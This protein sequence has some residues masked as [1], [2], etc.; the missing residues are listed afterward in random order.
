M[1]GG[2]IKGLFAEAGETREGGRRRGKMQVG[3]LFQTFKIPD[4]APPQPLQKLNSVSWELGILRD[5]LGLANDL[6]HD[7]EKSVTPCCVS[8]SH[9]EKKARKLVIN[10]IH[11]SRRASL[12]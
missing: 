10:S 6:W 8:P 5:R 4:R 11:H 12:R 7:L 2:M 1:V 3:V 9:S